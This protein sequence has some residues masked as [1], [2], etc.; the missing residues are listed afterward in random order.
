M[1]QWTDRRFR[2]EAEDPVPAGIDGEAVV[3]DPPLRFRALPGVLR[4]RIAAGHPGASPSAMIPDSPVE[5]FATLA[6]IAF[7][8]R[9]GSDR[10]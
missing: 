10:D 5:A 6:R 9:D 8:G 3:L 7:E 4:V 2:I 1:E